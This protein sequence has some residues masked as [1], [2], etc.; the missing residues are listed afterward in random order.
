MRR[1]EC[2]RDARAGAE[3]ADGEAPELQGLR[4]LVRERGVGGGGMRLVERGC[5][6][7]AWQVRDEHPEAR[8]ERGE[9]RAEVLAR[10]RPAVEQKERLARPHL[11]VGVAT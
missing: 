1:G 8:S 4:E 3:P 5:P 10:A 11:A 2:H 6:G 7:A 9:P